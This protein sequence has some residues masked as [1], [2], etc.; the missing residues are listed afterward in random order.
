MRMTIL[1]GGSVLLL[2][3]AWRTAC[4]TGSCPVCCCMAT[5]SDDA[6]PPAGDACGPNCRLPAAEQA[7]RRTLF[8]TNIRPR[9]EE[10]R[11]L[12]SGYALRFAADDDLILDLANWV[13]AERNCCDFLEYAIRV[14]PREGPLWLEVSG[15]TQGKRFISGSLGISTWP[16]DEP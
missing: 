12:E 6:V 14:T 7:L 3:A 15:D 13:K 10:I 16:T 8:E 2:L 5:N 9:I 1:V 11:E 4:A